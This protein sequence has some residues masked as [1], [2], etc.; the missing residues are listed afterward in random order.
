MVHFTSVL[1]SSLFALL[2]FVLDYVKVKLI[3]RF[4]FLNMPIHVGMCILD[5]SPN[6]TAKN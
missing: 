1:S 3:K 5:I 2:P 4:L 6:H